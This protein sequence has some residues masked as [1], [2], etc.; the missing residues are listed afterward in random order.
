M[1]PAYLKLRAIARD[2]VSRHAQP[3]FYRD[4]A[5]EANDA[6]H[7]FHTHPVVTRLHTILVPLLQNNFGHGM[8]HSEA[9]AIDAGTLVLVES[10]QC[11]HDDDAAHRHLLLALCTGLLHD[12]CRKEK[13]HAQKGADTARQI[14]QDFPFENA[15]IHAVC[16]AIRNHEAF[17]DPVPATTELERLLSD[18]LYDADKFRWGPDNFIHTLWD[19]TEILNPPIA[20]FTKHYPGGM[21]TLKKIR[22]TFRSRTGRQ[23]GP[24]FITIGLTVG[25]ALYPIILSD[26]LNSGYTANRQ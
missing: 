8:G 2:L 10:R 26:F 7:V 14:L 20:V 3:D 18:C 12:I 6:R 24:Q 15:E 4:H 9:V 13:N 19:M 25:E 11:R 5:D 16:L 22:N 23:Y 1:D 17:S 21:E